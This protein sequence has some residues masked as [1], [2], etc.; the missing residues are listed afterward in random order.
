MR[1]AVL[2]LVVAAFAASAV[3][4]FAR[5][6]PTM[7][8]RQLATRALTD[9]DLEKYI[10]ILAKVTQANKDRKGDMSQAALQTMQA[11]K[12]EAC[13]AQGWTTL[14]YG[15]VDS[16]LTTALTHLKMPNV[17]VPDSKK[18]DVEIARTFQ[19]KIAAA[20]K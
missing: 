15:V 7:N 19:G 11:K 5:Q 20:K 10:A 16:R 1:K 8:D 4:S 3:P 12:A 18:A 14:D 6:A 17:P 13:S 2:A 9:S